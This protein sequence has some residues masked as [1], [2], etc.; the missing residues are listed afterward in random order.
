MR[1]YHH[2]V[3]HD[4][5]CVSCSWICML[6]RRRQLSERESVPTPFCVVHQVERLSRLQHFGS[7]I[8]Q[9]ENIVCT[10]R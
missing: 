5:C 9:A 4:C 10:R 1:W 6:Q 3:T 7:R 2:S 8:K